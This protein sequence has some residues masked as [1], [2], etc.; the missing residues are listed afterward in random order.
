MMQLPTWR[1]PR[2]QR[3]LR[4]AAL[5]RAQLRLHDAHTLSSQQRK[6]HL[7]QAGAQPACTC[8]QAADPD[9]S[10]PR[11]DVS[12]VIAAWAYFQLELE[13]EPEAEP[14]LEPNGNKVKSK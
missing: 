8:A 9:V 5:L 11:P 7:A 13:A 14:E 10:W 2:R 1:A 4:L 6:L 12:C 3:R